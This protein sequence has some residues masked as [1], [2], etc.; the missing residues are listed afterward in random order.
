[1]EASFPWGVEVPHAGA[2]APIIL[3]RARHVVS[4]HIIPRGSG[5]AGIPDVTST[6][7]EA[8]DV[9]VVPH[10]DPCSM[11]AEPGQP[12]ELDVEATLDFFR[13]MAAGRLPFVCR[14]GGGGEPRCEFVCGFLGC[15]RQPFNPVLATPPRLPR[16]ARSTDGGEGLLGRLVDLTLAE[17]RRSRVGGGSI[18]LRLSELLFVEVVRRHLEGLPAHA[19]GWLS[20]LRDPAI[21]KVPM[22]LHERPAHA[23]TL[24]ELARRACMSRAALAARFTRL[25][26]HP[27]MHYLTLW[28]MQVAARLLVDGPAKVAAVA[29]DVGYGS[30]AAFSRAFRKTVGVPP[31]AWRERAAATS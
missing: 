22:L 31:A 3:P 26:G 12:P 20:G 8:G 18:R 2:S 14:E 13:G 5:W 21:G 25:V 29:R 24:D 23:W 4:Y 11:L 10:G 1:M 17:A 6:R 30:E 9:L 15:D 7:F 16:I 19:T 27:P 28:R